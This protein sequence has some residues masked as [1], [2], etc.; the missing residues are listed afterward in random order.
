MGGKLMNKLLLNL[1]ITTNTCQLPANDEFQNI[2][3][4]FSKFMGIIQL[5]HLEKV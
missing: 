3:L 2:Y 5:K 4:L 1:S